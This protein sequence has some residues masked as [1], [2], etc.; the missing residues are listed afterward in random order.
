MKEFVKK[1]L[2]NSKVGR[3]FYEPLH[4]IYRLWAVPRRRKLLK[5][6]GPEVLKD[7][8]AI[9]KKYNI[10][11]FAAYGTMLGFVRDHGFIAHDDD[12][13]I[14]VMPG[15][16]TPQKVLK[17]LLEKEKGFKILFI[18]KFRDKVTEFKVEYKHIP[19]DFFFY[20]ET[21]N[22]FLSHLYFFVDGIDYPSS[23][24][25]SMKIVHTPKFKGIECIRIFDVEFPVL[26]D[27]ERVLTALYGEGW[28]VPDK[29]WHDDKRPHIEAIDQFG[30]SISLDEAMALETNGK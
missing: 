15:A 29:G 18:F 26:K 3:C 28:R 23:N 11:A 19:I 8:A 2:K 4:K 22:E 12:M 24:A 6:N 30:Y 21:A 16:W 1:M 25:N 13:D 7:L 14:G 10:P 5:K 27:P 17:V 20:E 9:F